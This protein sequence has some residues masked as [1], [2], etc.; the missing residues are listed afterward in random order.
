MKPDLRISIKDHNRK[1]NL[2]VLL[3]WPPFPSR[4][5]LVRMNGTIWPTGGRVV[6]LAR[7][8][9]LAQVAGEGREAVVRFPFL[10]GLTKQMG[11]I[12]ARS[13][14]DTGFTNGE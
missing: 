4:G 11:L 1:K 12:G 2:K 10:M 13:F 8:V 9:T 6:S 14:A 3:F 7:L 5:F